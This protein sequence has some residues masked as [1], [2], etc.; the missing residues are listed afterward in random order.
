M[1]ITKIR[2]D[3]WIEL[4]AEDPTAGLH[5]GIYLPAEAIPGGRVGDTLEL[6]PTLVED[7]E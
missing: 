2:G 7:T 6:V 5:N 1:R 3:G 4:V